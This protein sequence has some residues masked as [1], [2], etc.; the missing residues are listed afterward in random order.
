MLVTM[1]LR[2]KPRSWGPAPTRPLTERP[3]EAG[4]ALCATSGRY[5]PGSRAATAAPRNEC[6]HEDEEAVARLKVA[7]VNKGRGE[8][9]RLESSTQ[10]GLPFSGERPPPRPRPRPRTTVRRSR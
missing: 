1:G 10:N 6:L 4:A 8:R 9:L 7:S 5:T 2:A 3:R